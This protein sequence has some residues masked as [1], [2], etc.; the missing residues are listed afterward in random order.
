MWLTGPVAPRHVGSSQTRAQTRVPCI[1]RQILNH[2]ATREAPGLFLLLLLL[3]CMSCL[4]IFKIN[5]LLVTSF[6]NIFSL[7]LG[8]LFI[9]FMVSFAVPKLISLVRSR[10][11]IFAFIPI[12]LGDW[13]K[14]TLVQFMSDHVLPVFSSRN[15]MLSC[16]V[17]KSLSH[18]EFIFVYGVKE[19]S[20]FIDLYAAV[21]FSQHHLLKRLCFPHYI[22]LP[23]FL[24]ISQP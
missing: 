10:L 19:C 15:F 16:L 3:S 21:Q 7:S 1:G 6:A 11:F 24:K 17:F 12:A 20:N 2:C 8:Y 5:P 14:K 23:P 22:F 9:L 18:F 13:P 4:Y